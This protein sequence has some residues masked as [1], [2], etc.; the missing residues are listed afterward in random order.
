VGEWKRCVGRTSV[1][2]SILGLTAIA[3]ACREGDVDVWLWV[4]DRDADALVG[5]DRELFVVERIG[6]PG[7]VELRGGPGGSWVAL[8]SVPSG[9]DPARGMGREEMG[10]EKAGDLTWRPLLRSSEGWELGE[11]AVAPQ[12][13]RASDPPDIGEVSSPE[14][15]VEIDER[16]AVALQPGAVTC[17]RWRRDHWVPWLS[18]GGFERVV[19][20]IGA[21]P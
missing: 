18:Q 15:W 16:T 20:A 10:R 12:A 3:G 5:L 9:S 11:V 14:R 13:T 19:D 17:F 2:A 21:D 4:A 8:G 6:C 7:P 1:V